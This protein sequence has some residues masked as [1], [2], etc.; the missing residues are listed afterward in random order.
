M[1]SNYPPQT[2]LDTEDL[3]TAD[4][5]GIVRSISDITR[6]GVQRL[7]SHVKTITS[8]DSPYTLDLEQNRVLL[9]NTS[10]GAVTVN[11]PPADEADVVPYHIKNINAANDVT[12]DGDGTETIDDSLTQVFSYPDCL[13]VVSDGSN[14]YII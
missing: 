6:F 9:V 13:T 12:L 5:P 2:H 8:S 14:W 7:F 1:V 4:Q 11:L 10:G 3:D